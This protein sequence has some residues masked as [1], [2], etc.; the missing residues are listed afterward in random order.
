MES[1]H[2]PAAV[3]HALLLTIVAALLV[4]FLCFSE[5]PGERNHQNAAFAFAPGVELVAGQFVGQ[6]EFFGIE[7]IAQV[8]GKLCAAFK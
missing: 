5:A 1:E 6:T 8:G 4:V 3:I 7:Q 2:P